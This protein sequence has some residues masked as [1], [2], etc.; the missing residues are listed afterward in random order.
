MANIPLISYASK[1][2][3]RKIVAKAMP[4]FG[5]DLIVADVRLAESTGLP[6]GL[7]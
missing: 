5:G 1:R 7:N 6:G 2:Y 4:H 3:L